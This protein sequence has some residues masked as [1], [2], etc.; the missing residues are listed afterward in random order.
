MDIFQFSWAALA[1]MVSVA[2]CF[3]LNVPMAALSFRI[4]RET[5]KSDIE[6]AELWQR[7]VLVSGA[8]ALTCVGFVA[9]DYLLADLAELPAGPIHLVVF[10]GFVALACW[11]V[12]Y[13][14]S[15]NDFF[16][17]LS[18]VVVYLFLP[19]IALFLLN[20]LLGLI[21]ES[22]QFWSNGPV[23]WAKYWLKQ[24]PAP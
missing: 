11:E 20:G 4:W 21:S 13:L 19:M 18:L 10:V 15:L 5:K 6:G 23:G 14:F 24:P 22:L 7:A 3:P 16:E 2:A 9:L 8:L 17:G 1:W 12:L